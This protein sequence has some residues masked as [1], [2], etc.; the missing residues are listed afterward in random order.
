MPTNEEMPIRIAKALAN[1]VA[2]QLDWYTATQS[3][4]DYFIKQAEA[5]LAVI[6]P[7]PTYPTE[8]YLKMGTEGTARL[9]LR[10]HQEVNSFTADQVHDM[11][12]KAALSGYRNAWNDAVNNGHAPH[13]STCD[14]VY[15]ETDSPGGKIR[16]HVVPPENGHDVTSYQDDE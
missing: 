4:R 9:I 8:F 5:A 12:V 11:L 3:T 6:P 13:C 10:D 16:I 14:E 15:I 7:L 2:P 1:H